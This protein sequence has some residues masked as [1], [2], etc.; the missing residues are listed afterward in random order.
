MTLALVIPF[1]DL[2]LKGKP[3]TREI[4]KDYITLK[5][6]STAKKTIKETQSIEW[7]KIFADRISDKGLICKIHNKRILKKLN[8]LRTN[9]SIKNGQKT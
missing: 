7:E 9:N 3:K 6:F 4:S 2:T 1:F 8:S 5:I